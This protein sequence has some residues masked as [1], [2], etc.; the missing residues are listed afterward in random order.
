M[1]ARFFDE[2]LEGREDGTLTAI[3]AGQANGRTLVSAVEQVE[4]Q[5]VVDFAGQAGD[6]AVF[7]AQP[8]ITEEAVLHDPRR[9]QDAVAL[10]GHG[11][12]TTMVDLQAVADLQHLAVAQMNLTAGLVTTVELGAGNEIQPQHEHAQQHRQ[13]RGE[14]DQ[15]P[16]AADAA[17]F[18]LTHGRHL[19]SW[20]SAT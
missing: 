8:V 4:H 14:H 7:D 3:E 10:P 13:G 20:A 16:A 12:E 5:F 2:M 11:I 6:L 18:A 19:L 17:L 9:L 1:A 15:Q